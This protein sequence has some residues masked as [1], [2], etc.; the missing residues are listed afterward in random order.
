MLKTTAVRSAKIAAH[1]FEKDNYYLEDEGIAESEWIGQ[2][3]G[4]FDLP[5]AVE[6]EQ[7]T[8]FL[9]GD[10]GQQKLGRTIKGERVHA[11]GWDLTFS[12]PKSVSI[13]TE[14]YGHNDLKN[15][16][17]NAVKSAMDYIEKNA[18]F[19]RVE[20][21]GKK[22]KVNTQKLLAAV[23]THDT[24][25]SLDPQLHSHCVVFN[26]TKQN[27]KFYSLSSEKFYELQKMGGLIYRNEL[28]HQAKK[29]GY[30]ISSLNKEGFFEINGLSSEILTEFSTRRKSI[31]EYIK[32]KGW[33][34]NATTAQKAALN[35]RKSKTDVNRN[36]LKKEWL[37]RAKVFDEHKNLVN[38]VKPKENNKDPKATQ[39]VRRAINKVF[40][41]DMVASEQEI[42]SWSMKLSTGD[43]SVLELNKALNQLRKNGTLILKSDAETQRNF[44]EQG[45]LFTT[46]KNQ[47]LEKDLI[48]LM[49]GGRNK[50][51]EINRN[52]K[53]SD[54]YSFFNEEQKNVIKKCLRSTDR[55]VGI[56]GIAGAGKT[57]LIKNMVE[58]INQNE[59][60]I[61]PLAPTHSAKKELSKATGKFAET[62]DMFIINQQAKK[63]VKTNKKQVW[64]VDES[65]FL[66][67]QK[68]KQLM[69]TA[70]KQDAKVIMLGDTKQ[71]DGIA[72]GRPFHLLQ[73]MKME[74]YTISEN[75][76]QK[77]IDYKNAVFLSS[78]GE[79]EKS[80]QLLNDNI[81]ET[82]NEFE[83][84]LK[85]YNQLSSDD[86]KETILLAPTNEK[87]KK[88]NQ[89][90][91]DDLIAKNQITG[92]SQ[93]VNCFESANF[94]QNEIR[95]VLNYKSKDLVI[96]FN[97]EYKETAKGRNDQID[98]GEYFKIRMIQP[99]TNELI[100]ESIND[101][102]MVK[103]NPNK[104]G[105]NRKG[106]ITVYNKELL[107][108]QAG[109][110]IRWKDSTKD[111][112]LFNNDELTVAGVEGTKIKLINENK[113]T[114]TIDTT[115]NLQ[116]HFTY[117]YAQTIYSS[118]GATK[119]NVI[120]LAD[121]S[122]INTINQK[123]FYVSI[124]RGQEKVSI[125]TTNKDK[126]LKALLLRKGEKRDALDKNMKK[127]LL[128]KD[129]GLRL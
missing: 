35:T 44:F 86:K 38:Q 122:N 37:E 6:P 46:K 22:E 23:F 32:N 89:I 26:M 100:I 59:Y 36:E 78:K 30:S 106:G 20:K 76:R 70:V 40:E 62:T 43:N 120:A 72:S 101:G 124:S 107:E 115:K 60:E 77:D 118:Q 95:N 1:Y 29:L 11:A 113:K 91:R 31:I 127:S 25:R 110:K 42:L 50:L 90:I 54:L 79:I 74:T 80:F 28:A 108:I 21:D 121:P 125:I 111:L 51:K 73:D 129:K 68:A 17:K 63:P 65:S 24:S 67:A 105:G 3:T 58:L 126:L 41:N 64:I 84:A 93:S 55:F 16:H 12:A 18:V 104:K 49:Q 7:F 97:R 39:A 85:K 114:I 69:R 5:A 96:R 128:Q 102:R 66:S 103:I 87:R 45:Q 61:I 15:A 9:E 4:D 33:E 94:S 119:K 14:V 56:Q 34:Y 117:N 82:N 81:V 2:L 109:D 10:L 8:K 52:V 116:K 48:L 19:C 123:S 47:N 112:G 27:N 75:I 13:L 57:T 71:L 92:K 83:T 53:D 99:K 88:L 98:K